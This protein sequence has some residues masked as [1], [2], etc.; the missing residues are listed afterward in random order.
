[1]GFNSTIAS[2]YFTRVFEAR[3]SKLGRHR[4]GVLTRRFVRQTMVLEMR[5]QLIVALKFRCW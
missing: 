2:T 1:M 3:K 5:K 4:R